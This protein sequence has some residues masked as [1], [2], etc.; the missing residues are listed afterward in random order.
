MEAKVSP[1]PPGRGVH[2]FLHRLFSPA[3][4]RPARRLPAKG[5]RA[6]VRSRREACR[7][8]EAPAP[9]N[10]R[11]RARQASGPMI[12]CGRAA[13]LRGQRRLRRRRTERKPPFHAAADTAAHRALV[14]SLKLDQANRGKKPPRPAASAQL[15]RPKARSAMSALRRNEPSLKRLKCAISGH[16]VAGLPA[17]SPAFIA[18][19]SVSLALTAT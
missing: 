17:L 4:G 19:S 9:A 8:P 14:N 16:S 5:G 18:S 11:R 15:S 12:G 1:G 2:E 6:D 10:L 13:R 7:L 3:G